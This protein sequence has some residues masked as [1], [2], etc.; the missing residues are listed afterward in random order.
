[1]IL[2]VDE[3]GALVETRCGRQLD[4]GK[5]FP[6]IDLWPDEL[7]MEG[8]SVVVRVN[9]D[10]SLSILTCESAYLQI[11]IL[12]EFGTSQLWGNEILDPEIW[13][14]YSNLQIRV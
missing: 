1:M 7:F 5:L 9:R 10:M 2:Y 6:W 11:R 12:D 8:E 4:V 13:L 14:R 3:Y